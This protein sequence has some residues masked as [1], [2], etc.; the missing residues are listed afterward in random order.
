MDFHKGLINLLCGYRIQ[1]QFTY[2]GHKFFFFFFARNVSP[3][4]M[5]AVNEWARAFFPASLNQMLGLSR[6]TA[7]C[8]SSRVARLKMWVSDYR[9]RSAGGIAFPR[10][11]GLLCCPGGGG[12]VVSTEILQWD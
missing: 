9:R 1:S 12:S 11:K 10:E 3:L 7:F 6:E 8:S 5:T 2:L 4:K